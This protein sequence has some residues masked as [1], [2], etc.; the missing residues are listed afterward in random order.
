MHSVCLVLIMAGH[1]LLPVSGSWRD[2]VHCEMDGASM[3][4]GRTVK[5]YIC[6]PKA[7]VVGIPDYDCR[8]REK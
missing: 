3:V 1:T 6:I 4:D 2:Q 5:G 7:I 8:G